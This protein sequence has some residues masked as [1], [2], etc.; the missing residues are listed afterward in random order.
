MIDNIINAVAAAF[1]IKVS[2]SSSKASNNRGAGSRAKGLVYAV[3]LFNFNHQQRSSVV[4][5]AD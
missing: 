2:S 4:V 1:S 3:L 5:K